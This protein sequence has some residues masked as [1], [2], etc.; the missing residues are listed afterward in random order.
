MATFHTRQYQLH[1]TFWHE[2]KKIHLNYSSRQTDDETS[3]IEK[4]LALLYLHL[5]LESLIS[6][7]I[8]NAVVFIFHDNREVRELWIKAYEKSLLRE[9]LTFLQTIW[10]S[11]TEMRVKKFS[12]NFVKKSTEIRNAIVHGH[13]FEEYSLSDSLETTHSKLLT[14]VEA[15]DMDQYLEEFK[16]SL[17]TFFDILK[18]PPYRERPEANWLELVRQLEAQIFNS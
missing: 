2:F 3:R 10:H 8:R 17:H 12:Q 4:L 11:D 7:C 15:I 13:P 1:F 16:N 9:K 5:T 6:Y 18:S 14:D